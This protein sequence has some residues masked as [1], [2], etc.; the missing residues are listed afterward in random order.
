M[1]VNRVGPLAGLIL[2]AGASA[3]AAEAP[4]EPLALIQRMNAAMRNFGPGTVEV[5]EVSHAG[6]K[7]ARRV[8]WKVKMGGWSHY[9]EAT[10]GKDGGETYRNG[11]ERVDH[12]AGAP[13]YLRRDDDD[14]VGPF[15]LSDMFPTMACADAWRRA[16]T[17]PVL[18]ATRVAA[19]E[20]E[21]RPAWRIEFPAERMRKQIAAA[22]DPVYAPPMRSIVVG[23]ADALPYAWTGAPGLR[24]SRVT[25]AWQKA[26]RP[27]TEAELSFHPPAGM[28][29]VRGI[30]GMG[31][32]HTRITGD[33]PDF[34]LKS[35]VG[36][37]PVRLSRLRGRPVLILLRA[38]RDGLEAAR[39][40]NADFKDKRLA[41][42]VVTSV[43]PKGISSEAAAG[44][45]PFALLH[46]QDGKVSAPYNAGN[47]DMVL[48]GKDGKVLEAGT[49]AE[50]VSRF[51][52]RLKAMP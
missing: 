3:I 18:K 28:M 15:S 8:T 34:N 4:P 20:Y 41:V 1:L 6:S 21:G 25:Y 46:D 7:A 40:F 16:V 48:I 24:P 50:D 49:L 5:S 51:R 39:R 2:L 38:N 45:V 29:E 31:G 42:L 32:M 44:R 35:V 11:R 14:S 33:A 47:A 27:Y 37:A 19:I 30:T 17:R 52:S 43:I 36:R 10:L 26:P 22:F 9:V 12:V 23:R 13:W